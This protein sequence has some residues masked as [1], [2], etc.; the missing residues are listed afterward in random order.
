MQAFGCMWTHWLLPTQLAQGQQRKETTKEG[1]GYRRTNAKRV[2]HRT[3]AKCVFHRRRENTIRGVEWETM[4]HLSKP[5]SCK[6][7]HTNAFVLEMW[8]LFASIHFMPHYLAFRLDLI[9]KAVASLSPISSFHIASVPDSLCE[10][11]PLVE[12]RARGGSGRG[13]ARWTDASCWRWHSLM[14]R[15]PITCFWGFLVSARQQ[16][17]PRGGCWQP[18]KGQHDWG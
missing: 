17:S 11:R 1:S 16:M 8:R 5:L 9:K 6:L 7:A 14:P 3:N 10:A 12:A 15:G 13:E 2:V 4:R 18:H